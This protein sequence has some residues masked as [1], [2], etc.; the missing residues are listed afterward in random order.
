MATVSTSIRMQP[1]AKE[2]D[3]V[4]EE[5]HEFANKA[6]LPEGLVFQLK[7]ILEELA[8]NVINYGNKGGTEPI[9]IRLAAQGETIVVEI[10]DVGQPF[11]PLKD[12]PAPDLELS[13]EER[14]I[15][16]LGLYLVKTMVDE[17]HYR[18]EDGRNHLTLITRVLA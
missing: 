14:P 3:T 15:G 2:L 8:L 9:E 1:D 5:V 11:D 12:A 18:W 16:G 13:L 7:L 6:D 10:S 17:M 4:F